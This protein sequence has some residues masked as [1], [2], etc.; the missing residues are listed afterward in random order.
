MT[1]EKPS[2]TLRT[3]IEA[4]VEEIKLLMDERDKRYDQRFKAQQEATRHALA[5]SHW[6]IGTVVTVGFLLIALVELFW[7]R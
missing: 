3:Y 5:A 1:D 2:V 4:K 7:K 6:M